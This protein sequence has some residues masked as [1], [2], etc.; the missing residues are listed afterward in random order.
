MKKTYA[1]YGIVKEWFLEAL[2]KLLKNKDFEKI[3]IT[4]LCACAGVPRSSFYRYF[5]SKDDVFRDYFE[6]I[7]Q[8]CAEYFRE[9]GVNS[10]NH[11]IEFFKFYGKYADYFR[12]LINLHKEYIVFEEI[13]NL[14]LVKR[15]ENKESFIYTK[16]NSYILFA[17]L[18]CWITNGCKE[19]EKE[20]SEL[21]K[22]AHNIDQMKNSIQSFETYY[23]KLK[24]ND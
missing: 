1:D 11:P 10:E 19:N 14:V 12:A 24:K 16:Y 15:F 17:I 8:N 3:T 4:E 18:F 21:Y 5:N 9:N 23:D 2:V 13:G 22:H 20:L 6:Y 7:G